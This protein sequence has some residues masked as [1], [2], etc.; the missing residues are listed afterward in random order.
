[1][2]T[3]PFRCADIP[4]LI[5]WFQTPAKL[6]QW[7]GPK[8]RFP[9]DEAQLAACLAETQEPCPAWRMWAADPNGA[10]ADPG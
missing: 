9:L 1:M 6:I 8:R 10:L 4:A 3:R 2:M 5:A 7:G